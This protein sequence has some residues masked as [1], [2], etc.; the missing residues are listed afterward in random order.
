MK[1]TYK[2]EWESDKFF[3]DGN[4]I[5]DL[6]K[7]RILE[8]EYAVTSREVSVP[9]SDMG[10]TYNAISKHY[11]IKKNVFGKVLEFDLGRLIDKGIKV[12]ALK[13]TLE[14]GHEY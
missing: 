10:H 5:S 8:N 6:K 1:L 7:V 2:N 3:V 11:Y 12:S 13:Y 14:D 4:P 9:Y